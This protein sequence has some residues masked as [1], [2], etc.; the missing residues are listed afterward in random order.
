MRGIVKSSNLIAVSNIPSNDSSLLGYPDQLSESLGHNGAR[1]HAGTAEHH[2][3]RVVGDLELSSEIVLTKYNSYWSR[4]VRG[5]VATV[6]F[7]VETFLHRSV[8]QALT[9]VEAVYVG[10]GVVLQLRV[11]RRRRSDL[12][13]KPTNLTI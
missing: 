6:G 11:T 2:V 4:C 8:Q 7:L 13:F 3:V 1:E 5:D 10:V 12:H 9:G